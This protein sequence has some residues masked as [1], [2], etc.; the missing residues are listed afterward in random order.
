MV[1]RLAFLILIV[2]LLEGT[3]SPQPLQASH[4]DRASAPR[5]FSGLLDDHTPSAALVAG[6]PY[7][8]HGRWSLEV[9][10]RRGIAKFEA[11]M[12]MQTSDFGIIQGTVNKDD[13]ASRSPHTHHISMTNG[14]L[15]AD[16]AGSCPKFNPAVT[17]GFVVTGTAFVTGNG[18]GAPF[19]NPSP[20]TVCVLGGTA[21]TFSNMTMTFG[22]PAANHFGL[23]P[24]NGVVARCN[25]RGDKRSPDCAVNE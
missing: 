7:A 10:E 9:D 5:R 1:R 23:Q 20:L 4:D 24:I 3:R 8:M 12:N 17:D 2:A 6:G 13:P 21:V 15:T 14:V 18:R 22:K 16:W 19:G 11:V 25:A